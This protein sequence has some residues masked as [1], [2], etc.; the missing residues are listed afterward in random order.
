MDDRGREA[1]A[2]VALEALGDLRERDVGRLGHQ[3]KNGLRLRF[4]SY[5]AKLVTGLGKEGGVSVAV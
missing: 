3:R 5:A 4:E 2:V 1:F